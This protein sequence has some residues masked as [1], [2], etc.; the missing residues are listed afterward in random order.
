VTGGVLLGEMTDD[1]LQKGRAEDTGT[2]ETR[3]FS[4][5]DLVLVDRWSMVFVAV[6]VS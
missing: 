6:S 3:E 2:H 4:Y 5:G 1:D